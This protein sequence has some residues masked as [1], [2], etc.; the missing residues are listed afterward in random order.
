M[1]ADSSDE[2]AYPEDRRA[3]VPQAAA[4]AGD[5]AGPIAAAAGGSP[6][7][8]EAAAAEERPAQE[9][10]GQQGE[11]AEDQGEDAENRP[12]AAPFVHIP[13]EEQA[14]LQVGISVRA[15][16]RDL[17]R[18]RTPSIGSGGRLPAFV[19]YSCSAMRERKGSVGS[20]PDA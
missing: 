13:Q 11:D 5:G 15:F 9:A 8:G 19:W 4:D 6:A 7:A 12:E 17:S 2:E 16:G 10:G 3:E 14:Q 18:M 1:S 20:G